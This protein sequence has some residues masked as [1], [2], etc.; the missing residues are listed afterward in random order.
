[1]LVYSLR[2]GRSSGCGK[3]SDLLR[4]FSFQLGPPVGT[5]QEAWPHGAP[6]LWAVAGPQGPP[7]HGV[8]RCALGVFRYLRASLSL[9][10]GGVGDLLLGR[11]PGHP[12]LG[13]TISPALEEGEEVFTASFVLLLQKNVL[14]ANYREEPFL[15]FRNLF[16][17]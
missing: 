8:S 4:G 9:R 5:G 13:P 15:G 2:A 12:A 3:E 1:M 7:G 17:T 10:G 16:D 14:P 6:V 11:G